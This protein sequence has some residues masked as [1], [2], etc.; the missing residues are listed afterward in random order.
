MMIAVILAMF[1]KFG[2]TG[3]KNNTET[4]CFPLRMSQKSM[5]G[6]GEHRPIPPLLDLKSRGSG[7][8]RRQSF[9][10]LAA[11]P[12]NMASAR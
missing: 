10:L 11:L 9:L 4:L 3:W 7:T 2:R 6:I 1:A 8:H 5:R 12:V